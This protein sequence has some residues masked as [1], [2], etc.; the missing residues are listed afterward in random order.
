MVLF[1]TV[2]I[3]DLSKDV[4]AKIQKWQVKIYTEVKGRMF[5]VWGGTGSAKALR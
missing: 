3:A 1:Y 4:W 2:V 5:Q